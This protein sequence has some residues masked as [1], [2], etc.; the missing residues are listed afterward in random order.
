MELFWENSN[1]KHL[2]VILLVIW[3][4]DQVLLRKNQ[5]FFNCLLRSEVETN[6]EY[7]HWRMKL[8][9]HEIEICLRDT[10]CEMITIDDV[11]GYVT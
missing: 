8:I 10:T 4:D 11:I 9:Q 5:H 7:T 6:I 3:C 1:P 2:Y